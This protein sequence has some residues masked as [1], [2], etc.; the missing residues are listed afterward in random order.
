ML[1]DILKNTET[2]LSS[3]SKWNDKILIR[4]VAKDA[5]D[6]KSIKSKLISCLSNQNL[7]KVWNS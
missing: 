3:H 5:Y 1:T 4:M 2:V 7:P 6:L